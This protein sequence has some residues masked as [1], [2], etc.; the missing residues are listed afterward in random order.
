MNLKNY[1]NKIK[2]SHGNIMLQIVVIM[3]IIGGASVYVMQKTGET[4]KD[5]SRM[6]LH[7]DAN[8]V[9]NVIHTIMSDPKKCELTFNDGGPT[10][11]PSKLV[12]QLNTDGSIK[13]YKYPTLAEDADA[14]FGNTHFQIDHYELHR[15]MVN[16]PPKDY[17][18]IRVKKM[19][20]MKGGS[21]DETVTKRVKMYVDWGPGNVVKSCRSLSDEEN[22][23]WS[24]GDGATIYYEGKVSA[25]IL[26]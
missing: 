4:A 14:R 21:T 24:R 15:D 9:V 11:S 3:G 10:L 23:I 20:I 2:N 22:Q 18:F 12:S 16:T 25:H 8:L 17:L 19:K 26:K 1:I 7:N 6:R 5:S 13:D